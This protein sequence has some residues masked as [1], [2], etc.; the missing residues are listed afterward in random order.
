MAAPPPEPPDETG[1]ATLERSSPAL[2]ALFRTLP[3][4]ASRSM[5]DLGPAGSRHLRLLGRYARQ[6]RFAGLLP[7]PH[8]DPTWAESIRSLPANESDPYDVVLAWDLLDR[9]RPEERPALIER[10][11]RITAPGA[12]VYFLVRSS[13]AT[14]IRPIHFTLL[15]VDRVGQREVGPPEPAQA[16]LVPAQVERMLPPFRVTHAYYLRSGW[17]EY[18]VAKGD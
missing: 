1:E 2:A 10:I 5:L 6:I 15:D 3:D 16:E 14:L 11:D 17:R 8:G 9:V 7:R 13:A 18:L 4:D 12:R